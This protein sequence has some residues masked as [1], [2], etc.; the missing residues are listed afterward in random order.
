MT[1]NLPD[2][3]FIGIIIETIKQFLGH[4]GIFHLEIDFVRVFHPKNSP[5]EINTGAVRERTVFGKQQRKK[6]KLGFPIVY[7]I[8]DNQKRPSDRTNRTDSYHCALVYRAQ[9][10]SPLSCAEKA[11]LRALFKY[12]SGLAWEMGISKGVCSFS[13]YEAAAPPALHTIYS[14]CRMEIH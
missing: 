14:V 11:V 3:I 8:W 9:N 4:I 5:K 13:C 2:G 7:V 12:L 1:S 6:W 10:T